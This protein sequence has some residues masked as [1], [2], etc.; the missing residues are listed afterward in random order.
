M[1]RALPTTSRKRR[2]ISLLPIRESK[3]N[4]SS[5]RFGFLSIATCSSGTMIADP[6][7]LQKRAIGRLSLLHL[8]HFILLF[9]KSFTLR[10]YL[11]DPSL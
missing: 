9:K 11:V 10:Y 5:L 4:S 8:V 6:H 2:T 1:E 7:H 3:P